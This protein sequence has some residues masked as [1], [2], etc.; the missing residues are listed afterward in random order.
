MATKT[1]YE[2]I[3]KM[4]SLVDPEIIRLLYLA[5]DKGVKLIS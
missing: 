1:I 4:N 3:A 5:S 2:I